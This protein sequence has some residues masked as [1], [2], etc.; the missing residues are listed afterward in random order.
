MSF[1]NIFKFEGLTGSD[2]L[3]LGWQ[4]RFWQQKQFWRLNNF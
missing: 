1:G 3:N 4:K 2:S